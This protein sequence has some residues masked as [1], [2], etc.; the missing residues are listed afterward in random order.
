MQKL[1]Q[2]HGTKSNWV[3]W[4]WASLQLGH[5]DSRIYKMGG[6]PNSS[7]PISWDPFHQEG[8][9]PP[10]LIQH[11]SSLLREPCHSIQPAQDSPRKGAFKYHTVFY[12]LCKPKIA[13][14]KCS[15]KEA[16]DHIRMTSSW[17]SAYLHQHPCRCHG[18]IVQCSITIKLFI[19]LL[20]DTN[21]AASVIF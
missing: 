15:V 7:I 14:S 5:D 6:G 1:D 20:I 11:L 16:E 17:P 8:C 18:R 10:S 19:L 21:H 13:S 12:Q 4:W 3:N 9:L 2:A